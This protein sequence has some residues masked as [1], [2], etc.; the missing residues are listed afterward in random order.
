MYLPMVQEPGAHPRATTYSTPCTGSGDYK[1]A[2]TDT[3]GCQSYSDVHVDTTECT[4]GADDIG[5]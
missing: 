5:N 2:V 3:N 1:V 4:T